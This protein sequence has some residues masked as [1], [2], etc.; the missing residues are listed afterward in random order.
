MNASSFLAPARDCAGVA[1]EWGGQGEGS[2]HAA[3]Q[4]STR[5]VFLTCKP[6]TDM[7]LTDMSWETRRETTVCST[8]QRKDAEEDMRYCSRMQFL[9][10]PAAFEFII[11]TGIF[12]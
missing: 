4:S 6:L 11:S 5:G 10:G 12:S 9:S 1:D 2:S 8:R 7:S 3:Q